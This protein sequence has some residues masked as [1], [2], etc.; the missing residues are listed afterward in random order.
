VTWSAAVDLVFSNSANITNE[1]G[2]TITVSVDKSILN[3]DGTGQF[4]NLGGSTFRKTAGALTIIDMRTRN[5]R[6][7]NINEM[8]G[9]F[10]FTQLLAN[11]GQI[12]L[13]GTG[14]DA[15]AGLEETDGSITFGPN[16]TLAVTGTF[17]LAGG[18]VGLSQTGDSVAVTGDLLVS[19]G[20][21]TLAG[22]SGGS[23][24]TATVTGNY[25]QT[26][27]STT[28]NSLYSP[29][30][31]TVRGLPRRAGGQLLPLRGQPRGGRGPASSIPRR[32]LRLRVGHR[33]R[34]QLG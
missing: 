23:G 24:V 3:P 22:E 28:V 4:M 14:L 33:E 17:L 10:R 26:A 30:T 8:V 27:G 31:M 29:S 21:L 2:A 6:Q 34:D 16:S 18:S 13:F 20:A 7:A 11:A 5:S 15:L 19:G 25:T 32:L 1:N 9:K 12:N